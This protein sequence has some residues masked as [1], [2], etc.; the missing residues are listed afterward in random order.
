MSIQALFPRA[1][2]APPATEQ[3]IAAAEA[4]LGVRFPAQLRRFYLECDGFREDRGNAKY[5]LSL[6]EP[7]SVGSLVATT[8][9][10]W[11]EW[12]GFFPE[13]DFRP[14]VFFG[15]S[16]GDDVWAIDWSR[17]DRII[18]YHHHLGAEYEVA[19]RDILE[20]WRADYAQ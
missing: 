18:R 19:G 4:T 17:G 15:F 3:A 13:L 1:R 6:A 2:L 20:V 7:D 9:F 8:R 16:G 5:L 10:Y 14:F 12:P 11:E